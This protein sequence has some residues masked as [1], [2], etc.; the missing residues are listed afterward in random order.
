MHLRV[1]RT[2]TNFPGDEDLDLWTKSKK[3]TDRGA[4]QGPKGGAKPH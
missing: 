2:T 4:R 1:F 3:K